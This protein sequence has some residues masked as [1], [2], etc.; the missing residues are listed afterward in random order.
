MATSKGCIAGDLQFRDADASYVDCSQTSNVSVGVKVDFTKHFTVI[1]YVPKCTLNLCCSLKKKTS[2]S[3]SWLTYVLLFQGILIPSHVTG[4]TCI[5][6]CTGCIYNRPS[7]YT[8]SII[9]DYTRLRLLWTVIVSLTLITLFT[10]YLDE[11]K[12]VQNCF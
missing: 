9:N 6:L 3:W 1:K 2:I 4:I 8:L 7:T 12:N 5:L 10:L 11:L